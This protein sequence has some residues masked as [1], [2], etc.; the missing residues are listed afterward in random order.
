MSS[1]WIDFMDQRKQSKWITQHIPHRVRVAIARLE[2]EDSL[3]RQ[4]HFEFPNTDA[5]RPR[6][7]FSE[8]LRLKLDKPVLLQMAT[9]CFARKSHGTKLVVRCCEQEGEKTAS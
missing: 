6:H 7:R 5:E 9:N 2:M 4:L 1:D 8:T 3:L